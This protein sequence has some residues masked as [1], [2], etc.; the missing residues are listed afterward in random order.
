[1]DTEVENFTLAARRIT[2]IKRWDVA[3]AAKYMLASLL[4]VSRIVGRFTPL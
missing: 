1:L 3:I 2:M 4:I